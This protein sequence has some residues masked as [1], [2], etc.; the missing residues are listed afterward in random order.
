MLIMKNV[1]QFPPDLFDPQAIARIQQLQKDGRPD[2][3]TQF[4]DLFLRSAEDLMNDLKKGIKNNDM[5]KTY[6]ALHTLRSSSAHLGLTQF[7]EL[8]TTLELAALRNEPQIISRHKQNLEVQFDEIE[9]ILTN[10]L[11]LQDH[12]EVVE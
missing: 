7:I 1:N 5:D 4:V 8:C 9:M 2:I 11:V 3:L 6:Y 10:Y 12:V